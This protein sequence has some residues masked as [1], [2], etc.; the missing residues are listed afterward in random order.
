MTST[1]GHIPAQTRRPPTA[2]HKRSA[3]DCSPVNGKP[4]RHDDHHPAGHSGNRGRQ[5]AEPTRDL[6]PGH[7][8]KS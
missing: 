7:A 5:R 6:G 8:L 3:S 1:L 4:L 2:H